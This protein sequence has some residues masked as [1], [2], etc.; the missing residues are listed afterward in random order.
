MCGVILMTGN[1]ATAAQVTDKA[2][3][4]QCKRSIPFF[5]GREKGEHGEGNR[6]EEN[7]EGR[8]G[9]DSRRVEW[10][11]KRARMKEEWEGR[12]GI[13]RDGAYKQ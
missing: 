5:K 3:P 6:T 4:L 1:E 10:E 11:N 9:N 13:E 12:E 8:F 2:T 7:R